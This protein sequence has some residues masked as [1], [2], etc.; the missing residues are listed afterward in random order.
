MH[1]VLEGVV[2]CMLD[3]W[4]TSAGKP[5]YLTI[6][7]IDTSL[8][9]QHPPHDF[10]R[11]PRSILKHRKFWKASKFRIW[12]LYYSLPLLL[13][14]LPT[15]YL[16][17]SCMCASHIAPTSTI[18]F[19]NRCRSNDAQRFCSTT[20]RAL[21]C[22]GVYS[23]FS[24]FTP[25][26]RCWGPLWRYSAFGFEHKNGFLTGHIHSPHKIADQLV[27]SVNLNHT[28]DNFQDQN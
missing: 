16:R 28:L 7:Q 11:A 27:F 22:Q 18:I 24:P 1:C 17:T 6:K 9:A 21:Q 12:L 23:E 15:L 2:K 5:Y 25:P 3:K 10:T 19:T 20:S 14:S 13:G 26:M 8:T 4:T